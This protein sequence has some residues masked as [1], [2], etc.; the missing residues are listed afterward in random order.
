M[1]YPAQYLG[2]ISHGANTPGSVWQ[3]YME[4][5][6]LASGSAAASESSCTNQSFVEQ[7]VHDQGRYL[8]Y[9][10]YLPSMQP[11]EPR[12]GDVYLAREGQEKTPLAF[13]SYASEKWELWQRASALEKAHPE[14]PTKYLWIDDNKIQWTTRKHIRTC[15]KIPVEDFQSI[16]NSHISRLSTSTEKEK[17]KRKR[18]AAVQSSS[19]KRSRTAIDPPFSGSD[20]LLSRP[21]LFS[22]PTTNGTNDANITDTLI[23]D[24]PTISCPTS[25]NPGI[26]FVSPVQL[27]AGSECPPTLKISEPEVSPA[28][29]LTLSPPLEIF[30]ASLLNPLP[31]ESTPENSPAPPLIPPPPPEIPPTSLLTPLSQES[32]P[33]EREMFCSPP[34]TPPPPL[35]NSPASVL[36]PLPQD[37]SPSSPSTPSTPSFFHP[38]EDPFNAFASDM[39]LKG[40]F[41]REFPIDAPT[42]RWKNGLET[43]L[44]FLKA[45]NGPNP[46]S[47][48][49]ETFNW[50]ISNLR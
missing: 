17:S 23:P 28:P 9:K 46:V 36:T 39:L 29:P 20:T 38:S 6:A 25:N 47:A 1:S 3:S 35:D 27:E 45:Q 12:P 2:P 15:L 34:S 48:P 5:S 30:P 24:P 7:S 50:R 8:D 44:P 31:Q 16:L 33:L 43:I 41:G 10:V 13:V 26:T 22:F 37:S 14:A 49:G 4:V 19:N 42:V 40:R 18:K 32:S 11:P 21:N